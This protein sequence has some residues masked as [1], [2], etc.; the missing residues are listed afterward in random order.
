MLFFIYKF[1]VAPTNKLLKIGPDFVNNLESAIV[2][3]TL[4]MILVQTNNLIF[5]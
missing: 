1:L 3:Q 5:E 4:Q 2:Q